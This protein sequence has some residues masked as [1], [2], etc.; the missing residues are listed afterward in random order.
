MAEKRALGHQPRQFAARADAELAVRA[1]QV[2]L[3]G[4]DAHEQHLA[5]LAVAPPRRDELRDAPLGRR[6]AR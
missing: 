3:D 4:A 5:D 2:S 1:R 6:R